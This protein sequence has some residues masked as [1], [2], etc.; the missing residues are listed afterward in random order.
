MRILM[1]EYG[2]NACI[3]A[4][5]DGH[6]AAYDPDGMDHT[7]LIRLMEGNF[8]ASNFD[9]TKLKGKGAFVVS[10]E[11]PDG[12][13]IRNSLHNT[14]VA[15]IFIPSGGRPDTINMGNWKDFLRIDGTPSAKGIV[16]GANIFI[17]KDARANLEK[18]G[19]LVVPGPSANKTGVI[20]SSYEILAGLILNEDEFLEIK[21]LYVTQLLDI[22]RVRARSEARVLMREFKLA[23]GSRTITELSYELSESINSLADTV[24]KVLEESVSV[25]ADD[26]GL[27]EVL[28]S[29]CPAILVEKY[30]ERIINDLPRGHQ[31]ALLSSFVSAKMLYQ[32]GMGWADKL[33][34][35]RGVRE[36]IFGYLEQEKIV[37][38]L[39]AE[40][41][42]CG[43]EHSR[44]E[45]QHV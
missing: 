18:V 40:V 15:D 35:I 29:Y 22:L 33:V 20:C 17:S 7:E 31:L 38:A 21:D 36:V 42:A 30:R 14:A 34:S 39:I 4:M 10:T 11:D 6:G 23:G 24:D 12:A 19:A 25:V 16:E 27:T 32:E 5:T 9:K 37:A 44:S 45:E 26:P 28:L 2:D 43:L 41:R 13:R 8:K 3:V 1:R